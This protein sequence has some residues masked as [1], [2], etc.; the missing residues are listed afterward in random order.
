MVKVSTNLAK[1]ENNLWGYHFP[2]KG[3]LVSSLVEDKKRR[4]ICT[5]NGHIKIQ[6]AL[7]PLKKD[8]Y[9]LVNQKLRAAL[10]LRNGDNVALMLEKD[11][12]QY[13][14]EMPE[15]L[16][17]TLDQDET[18][19]KHFRKLSP[20]KQRNLIYLV[21]KVKNIESQINKSLAIA[22][23]LKEQNGALNFKML[24]DTIKHFNQNHLS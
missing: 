14:M 8:F 20:G 13:G 11:R 2:I 9:I 7:M 1:F 10:G 24:N 22:H 12:T 6:C 21:K 19:A 17:T 15:T 18:A 4:V 5:I 23:H 16:Q 3:E